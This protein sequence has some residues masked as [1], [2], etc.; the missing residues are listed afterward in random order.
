MGV[1]FIFTTL[2]FLL[3]VPP[4]GS[5]YAAGPYDGTWKGTARSAGGRCERAS[6]DLT[7]EG[8]IVLGQA[9][10]G[11]DTSSIKGSVN[12]SGVVGATIGFQPLKGEFRADEF[13]GAFQISDCRWEAIL[14]RT[15]AGSRTVEERNPD[16]FRRPER[17]V[18]SKPTNL[19]HS[20]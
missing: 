17:P 5:A 13:R 19:S 7:V 2:A 14:W 15:S 6:V 16:R 1:W 8:R 12:E 11:D 20:R 3:L 4:L 9:K 10:I 18:L